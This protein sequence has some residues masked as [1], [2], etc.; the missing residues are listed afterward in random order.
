MMTNNPLKVRGLE[1]NGIEVEFRLPHMSG[2][3]TEHRLPQDEERTDGAH[4]RTRVALSFPMILNRKENLVSPQEWKSGCWIIVDSKH[5]RATGTSPFSKTILLNF[6]FILSD[7]RVQKDPRMEV[8]PWYI[9]SISVDA[10]LYH[11][12]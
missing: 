8:L 1:E 5:S 4:A 3:S 6:I 7:L 11:R 2:V 9:Q 10:R 12:G